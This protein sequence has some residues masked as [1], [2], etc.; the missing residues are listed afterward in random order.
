MIANFRCLILACLVSCLFALG[1]G[2]PE[3]TQPSYKAFQP[4]EDIA[5]MLKARQEQKKKPPAK[6]QDLAPYEPV[7]PVGFHA[8]LS[9]QCVLEFGVSLT[10]D[11]STSVIAY[12]KAVPTTGGYVLLQD[13][14]VKQM[15]APEFAAA[16]K[17]K[18]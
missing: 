17:A 1:C 7:G 13:G 2:G 11:P 3:K 15:T 4:L 8:L 6:V 12:E 14:T 5:T 10:N 18:K 9:G 16:P